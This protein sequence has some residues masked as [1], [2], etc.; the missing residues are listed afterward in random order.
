M[1]TSSSNY[2]LPAGKYLV[3]YENEIYYIRTDGKITGDITGN[4]ATVNGL[5]V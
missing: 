1:A 4:A 3:Y 5:T 2:T